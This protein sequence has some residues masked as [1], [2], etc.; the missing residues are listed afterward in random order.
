MKL[1]NKYLVIIPARGGS[2]SIKNKNLQ[3]INGDSLISISIKK[4]LDLNISVDIIV[5]SD[6]KEILNI[7]KTNGALAVTR[8]KNISGDSANSESALLHA[9]NEYEKLNKKFDSIIFHQCTSPLLSKNSIINILTE[10][11]NG[12]HDSIFTAVYEHNPIWIF[13][14]LKEKYIILNDKEYIRGP[15]QMRKPKLI[16]TG[17]LYIFGKDIFLKLYNRYLYNPTPFFLN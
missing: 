3:T 12:K 11:E 8:P 5:T 7:A 9:I 6:S 14:E 1:S 17:G 4:F 15:R 13:D 10:F 16:E 2:K